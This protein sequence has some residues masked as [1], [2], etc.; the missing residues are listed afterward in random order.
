ML[1]ASLKPRTMG[2]TTNTGLLAYALARAGHAVA[3]YDADES[4]QLS[5][6]ARDAGDFPCEVHEADTPAFAETV[7]PTMD[8]GRINVVDAGHAENHP[9]VVDS[10]L[11]VADLA[12]VTLS[13]TQPDYERLTRPERGTPLAKVIKRSAALRDSGQ[14]PTTVVLLNRCQAEAAS[15]KKYADL[16]TGGGKDGTEPAWTVL[17]TRIPRREAIA[18]AVGFPCDK[19]ERKAPYDALITELTQRGHLPTVR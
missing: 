18:S 7:Y 16:L 11:E 10:V 6:W 4:L 17:S 13:P 14:P 8:H 15:P 9:D 3:C 19:P 5:A 2:G 1:I 12:I